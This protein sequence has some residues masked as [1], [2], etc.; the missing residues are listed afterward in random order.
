MNF[1]QKIAD[2]IKTMPTIIFYVFV[3]FLPLYILKERPFEGFS[4]ENTAIL[5]FVADVLCILIMLYTYTTKCNK[6]D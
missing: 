5:V 2:L 3:L 4:N 6:K 1:F